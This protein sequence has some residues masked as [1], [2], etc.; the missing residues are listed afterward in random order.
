MTSDPP[1]D[2]GAGTGARTRA[3]AT[4]AEDPPLTGV[5]GSYRFND[6][7]SLLYVQV[8]KDNNTLG[9]RFKHNH[10]IRSTNWTA[11]PRATA[12]EPTAGEPDAL[13]EGLVV[14][15]L[16]D[17]AEAATTHGDQRQPTPRFAGTCSPTINSTLMR[18]GR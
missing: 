2:L 9:V 12:P 8:F 10:A 13:V 11:S 16:K 15:G 6:E 18:T 4:E 17:A 3:G 5:Q 14:D 1:S 7:Q